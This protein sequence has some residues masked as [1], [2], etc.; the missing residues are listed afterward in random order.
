MFEPR[1]YLD[2]ARKNNLS[3][4]LLDQWSGVTGVIKAATVDN[5]RM[6]GIRVLDDHALMHGFAGMNRRLFL[7]ARSPRLL[8]LEDRILIQ[9][10]HFHADEFR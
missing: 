1:F 6:P 3:S 5:S 2:S 8:K 9:Y 4:I 10:Q 7:P